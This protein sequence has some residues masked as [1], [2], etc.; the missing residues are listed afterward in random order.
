MDY[1]PLRS[2]RY[3][4]YLI[5][6]HKVSYEISCVIKKFPSPVPHLQIES[7]IRREIKEFVASYE[8]VF[9]AWSKKYII[10]ESFLQVDKNYEYVDFL[11]IAYSFQDKKFCYP[12]NLYRIRTHCHKQYAESVGQ[13]LNKK[14]KKIEIPILANNPSLIILYCF[15]QRGLAIFL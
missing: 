11:L 7:H 3:L 6:R 2:G 10:V 5:V 1:M 13:M 14:F 4:N 15:D 9:K 12:G 8:K